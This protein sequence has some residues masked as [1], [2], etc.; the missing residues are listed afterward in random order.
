MDP[1]DFTFHEEWTYEE[2]WWKGDGISQNGNGEA[3]ISIM[4]VCIKSMYV[5]GFAKKRKKPKYP[6]ISMPK[7]TWQQ[8][9]CQTSSNV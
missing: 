4:Y 2:R 7:F 8:T 1:K 6:M 9:S 5:E 3:L